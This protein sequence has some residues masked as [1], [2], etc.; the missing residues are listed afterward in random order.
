MIQCNPVV[1]IPNPI[2]RVLTVWA[3]LVYV[4]TNNNYKYYKYYYFLLLR[5]RKSVLHME[6]IDSSDA[7]AR[8][9]IITLC[10]G[11]R[12]MHQ[13][14]PISLTKVNVDNVIEALPR[15]IIH[16]WHILPVL[17][18]Q[19]TSQGHIMDRYRH[20]WYNAPNPSSRVLFVCV[21][22]VRAFTRKDR[23]SFPLF[24]WQPLS[25]QGRVAFY[26]RESVA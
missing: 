23:V 19:T 3:T 12:K 20:A 21:T 5:I 8:S 9:Q 2:S 10:Y 18:S 6:N 15:I 17:R 13:A 24:S 7:H 11:G 25:S 22:L 14:A 26:V 16:I 1:T 4:N